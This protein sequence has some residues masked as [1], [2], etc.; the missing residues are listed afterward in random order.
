[1]DILFRAEAR[2]ADGRLL[3]SPFSRLQLNKLKRA[4]GFLLTYE[5]RHLLISQTLPKVH[6]FIFDQKEKSCV[7]ALLG[8]VF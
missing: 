8:V 1:M 4:L 7:L 6:Q 5:V 2:R 3:A